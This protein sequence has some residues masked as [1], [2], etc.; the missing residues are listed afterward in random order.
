MA[1]ALG[2]ALGGPRK[3]PGLVVDEKWIG[4]GRARAT[5]ADIDRA[6]HLF[7]AA[8]LVNAGAIILVLWVQA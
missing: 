4:R 5:V 2:L 6:L 1:G 8:C 3:Y 7:S